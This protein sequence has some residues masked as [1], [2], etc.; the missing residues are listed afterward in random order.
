M[1]TKNSANSSL[2]DIHESQKP[3]RSWGRI[4]ACRVSFL[5]CICTPRFGRKK[6]RLG[7]RICSTSSFRSLWLHT[8]TQRRR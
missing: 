2:E 5:S 8:E 4:D 6:S 3:T 1:P 7:S